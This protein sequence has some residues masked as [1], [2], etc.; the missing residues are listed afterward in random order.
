MNQLVNQIKEEATQAL[1]QGDVAKLS[2]L[3]LLIAEFEK[4]K[5]VQKLSD[6]LELTEE[7]ALAVINRQLKKLDKEIEAYQHV[8]VGAVKQFAEKEVLKAYLPKQLSEEEVVKAVKEIAQSVSETGGKIG[9]AMKEVSAKLKGKA[10]MK[11]ASELMKAEFAKVEAKAKE[12][13]TKVEEVVENVEK[14]VKSVA[15]K[16][17]SK[18]AISD[19]QEKE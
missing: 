1:K 19:T 13:E 17:R 11:K 3:R 12:V 7:H 9:Q 10:D 18:K 6:V 15:K 14:E 4:E 8:G 16:T 2:T 5:V